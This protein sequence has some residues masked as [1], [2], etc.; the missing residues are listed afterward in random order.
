MNTLLCALVVLLAVVIGTLSWLTET[1]P[2]RARRRHR[3]G[4]SQTRIADAAG[5]SRYRV[6][7]WLAA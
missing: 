4:W 5:V 1:P 3:S 6:R 7:V 2:E